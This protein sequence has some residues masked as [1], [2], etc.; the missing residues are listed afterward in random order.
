M[1]DGPEATRLKQD[2]VALSFAGEDRAYVEAVAMALRQK[3]LKVFYDRFEEADLIGRNLVDHLSEV[4]SSKARLCILFISAAYARKPYPKMER[5]AAQST[6]LFSEEPYIIPVRLDESE[7]PGL[8]PTVAYLS[9]K[10][11]EAV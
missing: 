7:I 11:P 5:Q 10:T 4:Y 2:D 6:A 3:G 8:L 1:P 9:G